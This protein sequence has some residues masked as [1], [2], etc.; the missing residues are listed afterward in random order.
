M[1]NILLNLLLLILAVFLAQTGNTI[2]YMKDISI[3][4]KVML[5]L[6]FQMG[7]ML[8]VFL[9]YKTSPNKFAIA[10]LYY[11]GLSIVGSILINYFYFLII[12]HIVVNII[13]KFSYQ[14]FFTFI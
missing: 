7:I 6:V 4:K 14:F 13:F 1:A 8:F 9:Y 11:Y 12:Q 2:A 5:F 3:V 10:S